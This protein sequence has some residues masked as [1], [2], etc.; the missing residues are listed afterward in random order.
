[1]LE[2]IAAHAA[3]RVERLKAERPVKA[4]RKEPLYGRRPRPMA[5]ALE[6]AG[7][8]VIAE[9]KF[10]SPSEGFLRPGLKPSA[11]EALR[12]AGSYLAAGA[13]ALSIL[14][15][16]NFFAGSP[17]YLRAVRERHPEAFLLMKDFFV[18]PYQFELA[19]ACG[20]DAVLLITALYGDK[21][22]PA[23]LGIAGSLG[24][25]ALVEVHTREELELA[26]LAGAGLI[27]VNSRDLRTLKTDLRTARDLAGL[28]PG[29]LLIAESGLKS[30]AEIEDLAGLGY[31]GFLIGTSLMKADDPGEALRKLLG[32]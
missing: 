15:E 10:A 18:D 13:A 21:G 25:C 20:A 24:L 14:T 4:L 23:M 12:I 28:A 5:L 32:P 22:L 16:R 30:R 17:D 7:P 8:R 29:A 31:R 26:R 1:M 9:I 27:G 6:G 19:R 2:R 11:A 3:K